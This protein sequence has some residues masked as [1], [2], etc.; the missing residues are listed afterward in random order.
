[1]EAPNEDTVRLA[2]VGRPNVGKSTLVNAILKAPRV[3]VSE[4][5]GTTR[6]A[7]DTFFD[8]H[9][10]RYLLIDTAGI[11]RKGRTQQKLEKVSVIKALH[12]IDRSHVAVL[13]LDAL[14]GLTDQDLH[15]A[16]YIHERF[17][18]CVVVVNKW[19]G[20]EGDARRSKQLLDTVKER[21]RFM[22][23]APIV[24]LSALT[25]KRVSR[26]LP[27]VMEV[28]REYTRRIATAVVNQVL[29]QAVKHHEPPHVGRRALKFYYAT[30]VESA[31]PT[32][33]VFCNYPGSIHFSY[34]RYLINHFREALELHRVPI[35]LV[36]RRRR[37]AMEK[38]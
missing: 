12:S 11:R 21:L 35:K 6:D 25:G 38:Q 30:Q 32:F 29:D 10:Q 22:P 3:L 24:T 34:Q 17:R 1:M 4:I 18:G 7:I 15:V 31:P 36:F 37:R 19:D 20:V 5:P 27:T 16:G 33:V 8:Q 9:G 14:E 13:V 26:V 2:I 28:F 23:Y